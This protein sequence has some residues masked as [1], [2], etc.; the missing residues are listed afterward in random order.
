TVAV[1]Q[2]AAVIGRDV[3]LDL[4][5]ASSGDGIDTVLDGLEPAVVH[6]LLAPLSDPPAPFRFSHALVREVVADDVS[7]LRRARIHLSVADALA[8]TAGDLDDAAEI[9][10]DPHAAAP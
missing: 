9:L 2:V 4:L 7:A 5:T 10:P 6:R 8:T 3:D 1:L